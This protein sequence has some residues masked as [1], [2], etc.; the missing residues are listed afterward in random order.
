MPTFRRPFV[1]SI[2]KALQFPPMYEATDFRLTE[3]ESEDDDP[4]PPPDLKIT[5]ADERFFLDIYATRE[6][7]FHIDVSPGE[8]KLVDKHVVGRPDDVFQHVRNWA[9]RILAELESEPVV[10]A[11]KGRMAGAEQLL[12]DLGVQ[13]DADADFTAQQMADLASRLD[14]LEKRLAD[15]IRKREADRQK[16]ALE[17]EELRR[18]MQVLQDRLPSTPSKVAFG[19]LM[20]SRLFRWLDT[21]ETRKLLTDAASDMATNAIKRALGP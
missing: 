16:A 2:Q 9:Q 8:S 3:R 18:Q 15:E 7:K 20:V 5:Y 19:R 21:P 14:E 4:D 13:V 17:V 11:F 6:D 10:R 1:A 12:A